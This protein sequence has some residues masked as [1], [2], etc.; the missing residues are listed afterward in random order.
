MK[1]KSGFHLPLE[2]LFSCVSIT[3]N[4]FGMLGSESQYQCKI[5]YYIK[6]LIEWNFGLMYRFI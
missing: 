2:L 1:K 3:Q 5:I 4:Y 6:I